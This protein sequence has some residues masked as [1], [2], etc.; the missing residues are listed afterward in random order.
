MTNCAVIRRF[1]SRPSLR[2]AKK[3]NSRINLRLQISRLS[4]LNLSN[5]HS[6]CLDL[7]AL[8]LSKRAIVINCC[9]ILT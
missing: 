8:G 3:L 7:Y 6:M 2:A 9:T 4:K 5:L 1:H